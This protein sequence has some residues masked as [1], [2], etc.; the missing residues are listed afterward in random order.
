MKAGIGLGAA[1]H[2]AATVAS[3]DTGAGNVD[4][5]A[6]AGPAGT[7]AEA[8]GTC[9]GIGVAAGIAGGAPNGVAA[10]AGLG[11]MG[12]AAAATATA[13]LAACPFVRPASLSAANAAAAAPPCT[14]LT[15]KR[16][17][18][19][20]SASSLRLDL[21]LVSPSAPAPLASP[22]PSFARLSDAISS[23]A[24]CTPLTSPRSAAAPAPTAG[25]TAF[26]LA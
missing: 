21:M 19:P 5:K 3:P 9:A 22:F 14:S 2:G 18:T 23:A 26:T 4:V 6:D 8:A 20:A 24:C 1:V 25:V 7:A 13:G 16:S 12:V 10:A 11:N 15:G 17:S